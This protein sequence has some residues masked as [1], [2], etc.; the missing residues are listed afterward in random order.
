MA[1]VLWKTNQDAT[2]AV[3]ISIRASATFLHA[4]YSF[5][6]RRFPTRDVFVT[7]VRIDHGSAHLAVPFSKDFISSQTQ[8]AHELLRIDEIRR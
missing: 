7:Q 1:V 3:F 2:S 4:A 6:G 5:G 8:V